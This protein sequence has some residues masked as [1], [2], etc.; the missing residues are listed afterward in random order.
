MSEPSQN[1]FPNGLLGSARQVLD[2]GLAYVETRAELFSIEVR[3]EKLRLTEL[4]LLV[5][6]VVAF[7]AAGVALFSFTIVL[8]F[9]EQAPFPTLAILTTSYIGITAWAYRRLRRKLQNGAPFHATLEE[10]RKDR[11]CLRARN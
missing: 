11:E 6:A 2:D 10:L 9:W 1:G 4:I 3:E 7:G 8:I 5:A